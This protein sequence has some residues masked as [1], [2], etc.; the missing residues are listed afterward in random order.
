MRFVNLGDRFAE[1][2]TPGQL[3]EKYGLN[4]QNVVR[5]ARELL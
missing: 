5:A 4:Y 3:L 1:S 2:A